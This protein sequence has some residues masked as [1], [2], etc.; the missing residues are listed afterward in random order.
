MPNISPAMCVSNLDITFS[1]ALSVTLDTTASACVNNSS[2]L[3]RSPGNITS[4]LVAAYNPFF[5]KNFICLAFSFHWEKIHFYCSQLKS[6][7]SYVLLQFAFFPFELDA[8]TFAFSG[9]FITDV[10][11]THPDDG[12]AVWATLLRKESRL[13]ILRKLYRR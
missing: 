2:K 9:G 6:Y 3:S 13:N 5:K 8:A 7:L 10:S 12:C 11:S 4:Y 1:L